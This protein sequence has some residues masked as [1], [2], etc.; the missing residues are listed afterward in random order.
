MTMSLL[1]YLVFF[2]FLAFCNFVE[3][4]LIVYFFSCYT[5]LQKRVINSYQIFVSCKIV[6]FGV[7]RA[8]SARSNNIHTLKN[9]LF[10][11]MH[12]KT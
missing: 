9:K 11:N 4:I 8:I 7:K 6:F 12:L 2:L 3:F 1:N 5:E 10:I